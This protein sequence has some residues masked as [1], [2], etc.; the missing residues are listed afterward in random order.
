MP[1][2]GL[3]AEAAGLICW[4]VCFWWMHRLSA[5]QEAM[6]TEL[7]EVTSRIERFSREEHELIR[8]VHPA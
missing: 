4:G 1:S 2:F 3:L 8:E 7:H 5:R 6:L